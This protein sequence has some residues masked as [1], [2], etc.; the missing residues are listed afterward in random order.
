M[1]LTSPQMA[2]AE[3]A[4]FAAGESA[5]R[6]MEI[7][8][9]AM[10]DCVAQFHPRPG[11]CRVF[12]GKGH[13]G[14]DVLVAARHLAQAGWRIVLE[15]TYPDS[16]LAPLTAAMLAEIPSQPRS[17][18]D[19]PLVVLDGLLGIGI[20]GPPREPVAS[21]IRRINALRRTEAAWVLAAD[22]PSGL[23]EQGPSEPCVEADATL[24]MG[25]AKNILVLDEATRFVG[26]LAIAPLPSL[27]A[28][29][30]A[31]PAEIL[32]SKN[33]R[34]LLPPR[35]FDSHKGTFGRVAILAGSPDFPGAARLCSAAAVHA[36]AGLVT[37]F[38]PPEIAPVLSGSVIPEVMVCAAEDFS[39]VLEKPFDAVAIGP[40]LGRDR[41]AM[42]RDFLCK[43]SAPCV[44]DADAI[45]ALSFDPSPLKTP[46]GPRLLTPHPLEME[47]LFP[48]QGRTRRSWLE[49]FIAD[50]PATLLL[51][52]ARTLI[53]ERSGGIFYNSTGHPGMGTG[54]M[55]DVLTGVCAALLAQ[56]KTPLE[57]ARLG[58][59]TCG[60]AAEL[61]LRDSRASQESLS[62]I[63]VL[64]HLGA[65]F[66]DLRAGA[67]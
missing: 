45:N 1:I 14:G 29:P 4:A 47:R 55:G 51:K 56:K 16:E 30:D 44:V 38:V 61:A 33:L 50:Y 39:K 7:A 21:A 40:G 13:N 23:G 24:A 35:S 18:P 46:A 2:A 11:T 8:G 26:R 63:D 37:L 64:H 28:P 12:F 53:G 3:K 25:F 66:Q 41:D 27:A 17:A 6:L 57:A 52:G 54:G 58:A 10:A 9:R 62:A 36:G 60:R 20:S 31:D 5:E 15:K 65:A 48:R 67:L 22:L 42:V 59:W 32:T 43:T 34:A 19:S 49:D